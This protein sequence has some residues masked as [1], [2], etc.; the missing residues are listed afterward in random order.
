M[1]GLAK[2]Y[3]FQV[4]NNTGATVATSDLEVVRKKIAAGAWSYESSAAEIL[5]SGGD[6]ITDGTFGDGTAQNND[7]DGWI[8]LDARWYVTISSGSPSGEVTLVYLVS[9]DGT[10]WP[11]DGQGYTI[12]ALRFTATGTQRKGVSL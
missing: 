12:A 10:D 11:D 5:G 4:Y 3:R 2:H 9:E 7:S 6:T 8:G 1:S